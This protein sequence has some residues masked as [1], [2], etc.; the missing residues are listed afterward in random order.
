VRPRRDRLGEERAADVS[1]AA[2]L[3]H[4][5]APQ[6]IGVA[7]DPVDLVVHRPAARRGKA[8]DDQPQGAAAGVR[9]DCLE[10]QH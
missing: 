9:I 4:Q 7:A 5:H 10:R 8:V 6:P 3:A 1:V 2:R